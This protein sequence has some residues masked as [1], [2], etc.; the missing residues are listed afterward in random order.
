MNTLEELTT[1][2]AALER[3]ITR[4]EELMLKA[5]EEMPE[6]DPFKQLIPVAINDARRRAA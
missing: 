5:A 4:L 2:T 6:D 1:V 3:R